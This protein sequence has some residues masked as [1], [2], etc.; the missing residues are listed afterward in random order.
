MRQGKESKK[1]NKFLSP[2]LWRDDG[3]NPSNN[4]SNGRVDALIL[5]AR[6]KCKKPFFLLNVILSNANGVSVS[7]FNK[8][9]GP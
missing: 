7:L 3:I 9:S 4:A 5:L 8:L 1:M 2:C 6:V